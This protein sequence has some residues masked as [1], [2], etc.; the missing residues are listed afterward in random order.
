MGLK[1]WETL[2]RHDKVLLALDEIKDGKSGATWVLKFKHPLPMYVAKKTGSM[3]AI[4]EFVFDYDA[5]DLQVKGRMMVPG[6][7]ESILEDIVPDKEVNFSWRGLTPFGTCHGDLKTLAKMV[8]AL[9]EAKVTNLPNF[10]DEY[11]IDWWS[12]AKPVSFSI[13]VDV[14]KVDVQTVDTYDAGGSF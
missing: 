10:P 2:G 9:D 14:S 12:F 4:E 6:D 8:C 5:T 7:D 3:L 13:Q 1:N 11:L